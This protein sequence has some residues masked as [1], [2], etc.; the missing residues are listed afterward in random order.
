MAHSFGFDSYEEAS[1]TK[2]NVYFVFMDAGNTDGGYL[3]DYYKS[4]YPG[5]TLVEADRFTSKS[6][7]GYVIFSVEKQ[8]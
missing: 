1:L 7:P 3:K 2:D 8:N 5:Y 6:G 4:K